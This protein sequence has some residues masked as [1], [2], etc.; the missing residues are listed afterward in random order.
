M[1]ATDD[2]KIILVVKTYIACICHKSALK[3]DQ[4]LIQRWV[5]ASN[6]RCTLHTEYWIRYIDIRLFSAPELRRKTSDPQ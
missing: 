3:D 5:Q 1:Y 4:S 6:G 2:P